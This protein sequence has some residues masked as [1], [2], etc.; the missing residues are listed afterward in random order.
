M[1]AAATAM[2]TVHDKEMATA[3]LAMLAPRE[4]KFTFQLLG[5]RCA[6]FAKTV[7]GTVEE[8]WT[9]VLE[10]NTPEHGIGAFVTI[11]ATDFKGRRTENIVQARALFVDADDADQLRRCLDVAHATGA[12]PTMVVQTSPDRAHLY[13]RCD[14]IPLDEFS[15]LQAALIAKLETDPAV[16]D[17][18][19]V[20]RLPGTLHLK[21]P[22]CT[23]RV[24]LRKPSQAR[25]WKVRNLTM[26]LGLSATST[27]GQ[28]TT[29]KSRYSG[30]NTAL[31]PDDVKRL[32]R[33][34][35]PPKDELGAGLEANLEEIRSA[36]SAIPPSA[37]STELDWMNFMRGMAHAARI[38]KG[39][40]EQ[41]W[42]IADTASRS[43][44]GYDASD[45]RNRWLRYKAEALDRDTPITIATVFGLAKRH[46]WQG[47]SPPTAVSSSA[48][49]SAGSNGADP[50]DF[51]MTT[52]DDAVERINN[53]Y[54]FRRDTSEICRQDAVGGQIQVLTQQQLKTALA[55]R[56]VD[57]VDPKTGKTKVREAAS[58]WL[59]SRRRREVHGIQYCPNNVGLRQQ[60]LNLWLGWG[61]EPAPGECSIVLDH[62]VQVVAGG[63]Q[64]KAEFI[65]N[66]CAD[67][68]QNPTRKPGVALVLRGPEGTG[69]SVLGAVLRR[70]L[71]ERNVVV[72]ADKDRLLG[73]FNSALAG[74]ILIQAEESFFAGDSRTADALKHLITGQTLEI[75]LKFGRSFEIASFHR[76][77][78]TSNHS[79]VI[80]ASSEARR[81]VVCDVSARSQ[82]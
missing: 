40:A 73:R 58:I 43:A 70:L 79:Q 4:E 24:I 32:Q 44:P 80:Q 1:T 10:L 45:N 11:N 15:T 38:Y 66:W 16:K 82:G 69:K 36:V 53:E 42:D 63:D 2:S 35:G 34:L 56:W 37:I 52:A 62:I 19:R 28:Q 65:L 31:T 5:D 23:H 76:L 6:G 7:H 78:I 49:F 18:P 57:A 81:F 60:Y 8:F 20:M 75:E 17:L 46:G 14:D 68:L 39:Q 41:L 12:R 9:L 30:S 51:I 74:K 47:W 29:G 67:V 64:Q 48:G 3:F 54:F 21:D 71:G 27:A 61:L 72:N 59:E 26:A 22:N 55:G 13:W 77:L 25:H 50:L 33:L